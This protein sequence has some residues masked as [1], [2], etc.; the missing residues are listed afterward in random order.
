MM[1]VPDLET[2]SAVEAASIQNAVGNIRAQPDVYFQDVVFKSLLDTLKYPALLPYHTD[3]KVVLQIF[4]QQGLKCVGFLPQVGSSPHTHTRVNLYLSPS[5]S[6]QLSLRSLVVQTPGCIDTSTYSN[7]RSS[8]PPSSAT[9]ATTFRTCFELTHDLW[10]VHEPRL[11]IGLIA[12]AEPVAAERR[13]DENSLQR[14]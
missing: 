1:R 14:A 4:Q 2:K 5:R 10:E 11:L 13:L 12:C 7:S 6:S 9:S 3:I 8:S